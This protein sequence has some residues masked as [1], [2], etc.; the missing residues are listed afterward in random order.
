[1]EIS[2]QSQARNAAVQQQQQ[3]QRDQQ[4]RGGVFSLTTV[5]AAIQHAVEAAGSCEA[6][7]RRRRIRQLQLRWHPGE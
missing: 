4:D 3:Q 1:M 6:E 2:M 7:E 5:K